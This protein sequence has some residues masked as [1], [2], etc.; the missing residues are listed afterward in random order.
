M[1]RSYVHN[2]DIPSNFSDS[3]FTKL[4]AAVDRNLAGVLSIEDLTYLLFPE[5]NW[6][7]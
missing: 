5:D 2:F 1:I 7:H 4:F 3:R 6:G